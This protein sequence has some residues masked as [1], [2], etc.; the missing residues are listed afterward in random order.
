MDLKVIHDEIRERLSKEITGHLKPSDIDRALDLAQLDLFN[1][2]TGSFRDY[3]RGK[4]VR[5]YFS[6]TQRLNDALS[7]FKIKETFQKVDTAGG[8]VPLESDFITLIS[9]A[10]ST[11][12]NEYR[13]ISP[14]PYT[15]PSFKQVKIYDENEIYERLDSYLVSPNEYEPIALI[16]SK[17]TG[18]QLFPEQGY[19]GLYWYLKRP[20][21]PEYAYTMSGRAYVYDQSGSTQLEWY[22]TE[23]SRII[24]KAIT[25][26]AGGLKDTE[27]T[28]LAMAKDGGTD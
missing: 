27:A 17:A 6:S 3:Q 20:D 1:M 23:I 2:L 10:V 22:D 9:I 12:A 8:I 7:P 14:P 16:N 5:L 18:I 25:Y 11:L 19:S 28:Q 4:P 13:D 21:I 15:T 24:D 26:L